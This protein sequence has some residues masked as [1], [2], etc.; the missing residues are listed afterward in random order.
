MERDIEPLLV[1][2]AIALLLKITSKLAKGRKVKIILAG[3]LAVAAHGMPE[4]KTLDLDAEIISGNS[5]LI[6]KINLEFEKLKVPLDISDN[7]SRWGMVDLPPGYRKRAKFYKGIGSAQLY[8]LAPIDLI[9]SKARILRDIDIQDIIF[10][11]KKFKISF[12]EI[13][14]KAEEA[15]LTSPHS[16]EI[17]FFKKNL[18]Y[19]KNILAE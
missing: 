11:V 6:E 9:I 2:K 18:K 19:L 4:R 17:L 3:G 7:I 12:R 8:L 16:T 1:K 14:K 13:E 15:I 10:L 5:S